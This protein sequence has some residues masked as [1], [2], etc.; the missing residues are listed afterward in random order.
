MTTSEL[1]STFKPLTDGEA[2]TLRAKHA[3]TDLY[4]FRDTISPEGEDLEIVLYFRRPTLEE[5]A[6]F[7]DKAAEQAFMAMY[8]QAL[9]LTVSPERARV[10][11]LLKRFPLLAPKIAAQAGKVSGSG[12]KAT[13]KKF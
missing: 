3:D 1:I 2:A 8:N 4:E 9:T 5:T 13:A 7:I 12:G 10:I 11:E 6:A